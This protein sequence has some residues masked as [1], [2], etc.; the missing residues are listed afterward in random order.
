MNFFKKNGRPTEEEL[1]LIQ[2]IEKIINQKQIPYSEIPECQS[3]DDLIEVKLLL[4][5]YEPENSDS[6]HT[7]DEEQTTQSELVEKVQLIEEPVNVIEEVASEIEEPENGEFEFENYDPFSTQIIE[8]SYTKETTKI[9]DSIQDNEDEL[10]LEETKENLA[11]LS[12]LAKRRAAEQT[13]DTILK[14]Y[15]RLVPQPFKWMAKFPE[16]KIEKMSMDGEIN[17][18]IEVEE[19]KSFDEYMRE[20]N[21]Q[22]DEIFEVDTDTLAEI[23][24]PL[25]EVLMEQQLELTPQQRLSMAVISH[26]VQMFTVALKIRKDNQRILAYQKHLTSVYNQQHFS[27]NNNLRNAS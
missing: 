14:G 7:E 5:A 25:V 12:P 20:S 21:A 9:D 10:K 15:A 16:D 4:D 2:L 6:T 13:A 26:L 22:L 19:G 23:K 1:S 17:T 11:D 3:L 8:R 24:E 18:Q 27:G